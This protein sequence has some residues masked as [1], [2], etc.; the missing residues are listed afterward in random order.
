MRQ[1]VGSPKE[2]VV[3]AQRLQAAQMLNFREMNS[4]VFPPQYPLISEF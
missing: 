1:T 4:S 3:A 2:A